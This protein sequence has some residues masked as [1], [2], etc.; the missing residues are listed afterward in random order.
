MNT[1]SLAHADAAAADGDQ[2]ARRVRAACS[3]ATARRRKSGARGSSRTRASSTPSPKTCSELAA[4]LGP[5][6]RSALDEYLAN[7]REIER[8]IVHAEQQR[9]ETGIDAPPTP[10]GI[11]EIVRRARQR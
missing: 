3:A 10:I 6:D 9:Y 4:Q 7:V 1:I 2:P 8:R 5:R 11:P